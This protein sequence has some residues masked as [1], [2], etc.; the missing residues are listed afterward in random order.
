MVTFS[1]VVDDDFNDD[2]D[3][4]LSRSGESRTGM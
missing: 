3:Y 2:V 1:A 4:G